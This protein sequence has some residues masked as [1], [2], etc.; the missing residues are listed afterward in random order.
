MPPKETTFTLK[1]KQKLLQTGNKPLPLNE[2][3]SLISRHIL[4]EDL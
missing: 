3:T 1:W 4:D 2:R